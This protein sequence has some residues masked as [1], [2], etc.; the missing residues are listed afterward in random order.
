MMRRLGMIVAAAVVSVCLGCQAQGPKLAVLEEVR[1]HDIVFR[2][3]V[4]RYVWLQP[5][6][7]FEHDAAMHLGY[8][9]AELH[10]RL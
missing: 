3:F 8:L 6:R 9:N 7:L 1:D 10:V 5:G 2:I 4:C